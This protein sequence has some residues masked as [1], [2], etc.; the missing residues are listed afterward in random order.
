MDVQGTMTAANVIEAIATVAEAVMAVMVAT[1]LQRLNRLI[2]WAEMVPIPRLLMLLA[3]TGINTHSM[4]HT[5]KRIPSKTPM[6]HRVALQLSC[7]TGTIKE[8]K[9]RKTLQRQ[10]LRLQRHHRLRPH[11]NLLLQVVHLHRLHH[12]LRLGHRRDTTR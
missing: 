10:E 4:L 3:S 1:V 2:L 6:L 12:R 5:I 9:G 11:Q 8:L 7:G